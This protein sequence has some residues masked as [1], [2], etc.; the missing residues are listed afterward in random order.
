[1]EL[2]IVLLLIGTWPEV[3]DDDE[4]LSCLFFPSDDLC[5][6]VLSLAD[7]LVEF[8]LFDE[9]DWLL[10]SI[11]DEFCLEA[12][13]LVVERRQW[14]EENF[15]ISNEDFVSNSSF[16]RNQFHALDDIPNSNNKIT[17]TYRELMHCLRC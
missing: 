4:L 5:E 11:C 9:D 8:V 6:V 7:A 15:S 10:L 3:V 17:S 13:Y 1:M 12:I 16:Q 14:R 2:I